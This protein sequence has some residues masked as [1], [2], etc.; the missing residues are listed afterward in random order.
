MNTEL[1]RQFV[2]E[3]LAVEI[4]KSEP[5]TEVGAAVDFIVDTAKDRCPDELE[6][7]S[8]R[9]EYRLSVADRFR[10]RVLL[11]E[12]VMDRVL[13]PGGK[14]GGESWPHFWVTPHGESVVRA[15]PGGPLP[16]DPDGYLRLLNESCDGLHPTVNVYLAEA[17]GTFRSG[18]LL[19]SAVMLGAASEMM[20]LELCQSS[21]TA[22]R[23]SEKSQRFLKETQPSKAMNDRIERM[24]RWLVDYRRELP[25]DW[26]HESQHRLFAGIAD[27]IRRS[28]NG[29]GH[30]QDPPDI[31]SRE[32]MYAYL[33]LFPQQCSAIY[34]L[35]RWLDKHPQSLGEE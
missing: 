14:Y 25:G 20:F 31:P 2:L 24:V 3:W 26:G 23:N 27:A 8:R 16:Y 28:R 32:Q 19:S 7:S 15:G 34:D 18:H 13:V 4:E 1:L 5:R 17:L 12:M 10:L 30:P 35:K 22:I 21:G 6:H 9:Q 29:A 33:V 11:W